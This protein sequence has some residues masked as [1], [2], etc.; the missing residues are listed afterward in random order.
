MIFFRLEKRSRYL[1]KNH[2]IRKESQQGF[3]TFDN[4]RLIIFKA[5]NKGKKP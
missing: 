2:L 4:A 5:K 1:E 3:P